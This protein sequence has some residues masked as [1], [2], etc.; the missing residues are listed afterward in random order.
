MVTPDDRVKVL[1]FGIARRTALAA[2]K[3]PELSTVEGTLAGTGVLIGTAGYMS[4]E[5]VQAQPADERSDVFALGV[6][7]YELLTGTAPFRRQT[8]WGS[9][10]ATVY[11]TPAPVD[12][13]HRG[14]PPALTADRVALPGEG[15][16]AA[17][18]VGG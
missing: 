13:A 2:T 12:A 1:D 16:S 17:A 15:S 9:L 6:I 8:T 4:P 10:E 14:I 7:I 3:R 18:G 5:Q 11:Y